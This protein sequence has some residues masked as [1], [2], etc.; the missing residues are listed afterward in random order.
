[1]DI[2]SLFYLILESLTISSLIN[3]LLMPLNGILGIR[4]QLKENC[5]PLKRYLN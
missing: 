1:M 3:R 4:D 2:N 5:L